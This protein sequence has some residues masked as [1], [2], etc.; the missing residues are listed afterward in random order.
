[1]NI[2]NAPKSWLSGCLCSLLAL[3]FFSLFSFEAQ[4][5]VRDIRMRLQERLPDVANVKSMLGNNWY[6]VEIKGQLFLY[7]FVG[8][9]A[10]G[11]ESMTKMGEGSFQV[12]PVENVQVDENIYGDLIEDLPLNGKIVE[13]LGKGWFVIELSDGIYYLYHRTGKAY[14][15]ECLV[16]LN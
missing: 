9:Q 2:V 16:R 11:F 13:I 4:S 6:E 14:G 1:M 12:N 8:S 5:Q 15:A 10:S 7:H 3:V